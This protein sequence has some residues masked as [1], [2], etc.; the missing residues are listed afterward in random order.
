MS[1]LQIKRTVRRTAKG[2]K[3]KMSQYQGAVRRVRIQPER[4]EKAMKELH[5]EMQSYRVRRERDMEESL[6]YAKLFRCK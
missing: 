4:M 1:V 2:T 5:V 3:G 6:E